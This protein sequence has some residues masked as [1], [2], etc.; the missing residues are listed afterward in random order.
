[1]RKAVIVYYAVTTFAVALAANLFAPSG[2]QAIDLALPA[3][4]RAAIHEADP[5]QRVPY[6]CRQTSN[7]RE[8]F[9]ISS[10]NQ[11]RNST[12]DTPYFQKRYTGSS[13]YQTNPWG[14]PYGSR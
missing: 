13:Q 14:N 11:Q 6:V 10:Q 12:G 4:L 7:G 2:A 1:M 9:T 3:G 8:C 5:A